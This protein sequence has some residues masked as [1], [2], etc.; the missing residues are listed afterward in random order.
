VR[1]GFSIFYPFDSAPFD[2]VASLMVNRTGF[3]F[4]IWVEITRQAEDRKE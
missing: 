1:G 2:S 4:S 3:L